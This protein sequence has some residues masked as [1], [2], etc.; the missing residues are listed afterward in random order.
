VN[1]LALLEL[2][3]RIVVLAMEGQTPEQKKQMW[4]WYI[5]DVTRWRKLLKLED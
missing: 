5:A 4:D 2:A 3:L 1:P